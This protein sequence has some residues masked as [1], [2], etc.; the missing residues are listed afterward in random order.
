MAALRRNIGASRLEVCR[1]TIEGLGA[2]SVSVP[3]GAPVVVEV[4]L[5]SYR[6]GI[7][8]R[9]TA[10]APWVGE[11]RRC[12]GGVA[13]EVAAV[14]HERFTPEGATDQDEDAYP[15][16]GDEVDLEPMARDAVLLELP[17]APLCSPDCRGLCPRCGTNWN[18]TTCDCAPV[19]DPRWSVLDVLREPG[20]SGLA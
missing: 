13:S 17:L 19:G 14:L 1:G 20:D 8:A 5:S 10:S 6:G 18:S 2:V 15:M 12:G 11:C 16:I 9:G 3:E 4:T 7:A